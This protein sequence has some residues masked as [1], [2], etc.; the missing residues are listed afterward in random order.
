MSAYKRASYVGFV[1]FIF[2]IIIA[3]Y[4]FSFLLKQND[5]EA[6]GILVK[7]TVFDIEENAIY[8]APWVKFTTKDGKE[9]RFKSE[10]EQN[11]DFFSYTVGQEVEVI[12]HKDNPKQAKINAFWESNFE[13]IF[14]GIVGVFLLFFGLFLRWLFL[15]KA[16]KY[17]RY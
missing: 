5:L 12:Y 7:G 11:V 1:I 10:L 15:R 3:I 17:E 14:L 8:R 2:G 6:N 4:G 9:I 16:K 13:Q